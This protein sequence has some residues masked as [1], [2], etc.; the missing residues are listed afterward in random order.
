[1]R[2]S[3]AGWNGNMRSG[4]VC[5]GNTA[6]SSGLKSSADRSVLTA[7]LPHFWERDVIHPQKG[8]TALIALGDSAC[9]NQYTVMKTKKNVEMET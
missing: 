4:V 6:S 7:L 2:V 3:N 8:R 9:C 1:M 5:G